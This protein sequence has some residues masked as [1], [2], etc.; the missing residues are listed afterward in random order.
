V[1]RVLGLVDEV[2]ANAHRRITTGLLND[3]ITDASAAVDPPSIG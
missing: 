2:Y 1:N 3:V